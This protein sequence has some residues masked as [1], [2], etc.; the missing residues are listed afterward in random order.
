MYPALVSTEHKTALDPQQLP[1]N[2]EPAHQHWTSARKIWQYAMK[3][4]AMLGGVSGEMILQKFI[5]N[6]IIKVSKYINH[7]SDPTC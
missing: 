4:S 5:P 3:K 7:G 6:A 2:F 1:P